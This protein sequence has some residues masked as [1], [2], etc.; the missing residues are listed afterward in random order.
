MDRVRCWAHTKPCSSNFSGGCT[1]TFF[2]NQTTFAEQQQHSTHINC[3]A[4]PRGECLEAL[5]NSPLNDA[6]DPVCLGSCSLD[7]PVLLQ[8]SRVT[9]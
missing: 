8:F 3:C 1:H 7:S 6:F 5:C 9:V 4:T 2:V